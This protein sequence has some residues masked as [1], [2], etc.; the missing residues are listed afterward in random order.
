MK[1]RCGDVTA[2][3]T[4]S[5]GVRDV[6]GKREGERRLASRNEREIGEGG[7]IKLK[8]SGRKPGA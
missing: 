7:G 8:E 6:S 2:G 4:E 3:I 5:H 1:S